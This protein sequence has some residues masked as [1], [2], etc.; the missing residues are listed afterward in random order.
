MV[1]NITKLSMITN[2]SSNI[3][4]QCNASLIFENIT[5]VSLQGLRFIGCGS[6]ELSSVKNFTIKNSSFIGWKGTGTALKINESIATF[7]E[8]SFL[9][10]VKGTYAGPLWIYPFWRNLL[11][12]DILTD[13]DYAFVDGAI[14]AIHSAVTFFVADL[15]EIM[16]I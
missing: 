15:K 9:F 5:Q 10:N 4:C 12:Y 3:S 16:L 8:F 7:I 1:A 14:M 6:N 13:S 2:S 11:N